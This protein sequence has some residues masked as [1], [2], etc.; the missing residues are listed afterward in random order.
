MTPYQNVQPGQPM[1][2]PPEQGAPM[3]PPGMPPQGM[4]GMM[5]GMQPPMPGMEQEGPMEDA[6]PGDQG[7]DMMS[8]I[9]SAIEST[10]LAKK[11]SEEER[12]TMGVRVVTEFDDDK[13][14]LQDWFDKMNE[15]LELALL[16]RENKTFPWPGASNVK[17][18][19]L[20]T[21]AMQFSARAYPTLVPADN[22]I[23]KARVIGYD[24]DGSRFDKA[25][26]IAKHMSY[27]IMHKMD[28]W[29]E[30]MD[31]LLMIMSIIGVMFKKTYRDEYGKVH[32]DLLYP[33]N[34]I[35]DYYTKTLDEAYR[36][37]EVMTVRKNEYVQKVR[38]GTWLDIGEIYAAPSSAEVDQSPEYQR[39][40]TL[41]RTV[42]MSTNASPDLFLAQH[43]FYDIDGDG[44]EEP[45]VITVH[46]RTKQVVRVV[47]RF[48]LSGVKLN[49]KG[50]IEY[51]EPIEY[52]TDYQ[53]LP[54]PDG[55]IYGLGFGVLLGPMNEAINSL[56]NQLVDAGTLNNLQSGFIGKG[57]RIQMKE[58][59]FKPGE[60]KSVNATGEDL[61]SS[62]FPLPSKEPS[63]VLFQL[64]NLL[65]QAGN[66]LASVAEIFVGKMPGQN[67][68][69]TTTQETVDQAMKVFTAIYKRTYRSLLREFKKIFRINK[70]SPDVVAEESSVLNIPLEASDYIGAEDDV[71]PAADPSGNSSTA[72]FQQMQQIGQLLLPMQVINPQ[73]YANRMLKL[74]QIPDP[75][76][77]I[78]PPAP[79]QPDPSMQTEQAKQQTEQLKQQGMQQKQETDKQLAQQKIQLQERE[80][81]MK[82]RE[83]EQA[84]LHEAQMQQIKQSG[85]AQDARMNQILK[86]VEL[87][88]TARNQEMQVRHAQQNHEQKL[89][90][91]AQQA[92]QKKKLMAKK[93]QQQGKRKGAK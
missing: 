43:T 89:V 45:V 51:I 32:S 93:P 57:L 85:A 40:Q 31:R 16:L 72:Q 13:T 28:N 86:A 71:I 21:A 20:A 65:I 77:L 59:A 52:F 83:R 82:E 67:T 46:Y 12:M 91:T 66:Q 80:A 14:S 84:R 55:S 2:M 78:A 88:G 30:D 79:P 42:P 25:D 41:D 10:N 73:E 15:W 1:Q 35:C 58:T 60:W 8:A 49:D 48:T 62:I 70:L 90:Q 54:N 11:L 38:S 36:K 68:P 34:L 23:V 9:N 50:K 53:F 74:I 56:C 81:A 22:Q 7:E 18:P 69:A 29:E 44:Y 3:Q 19:L 4:E 87:Q 64:M 47:A 63:A 37:T 24:P 39:T 5:P 17:Y 61:K 26:R 75:Q 33:E 27:Q 6:Q 92:E 76:K